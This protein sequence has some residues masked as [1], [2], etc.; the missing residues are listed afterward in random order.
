VQTIAPNVSG[1]LPSLIVFP[2]SMYAAC[3]YG[4]RSA[5]ALGLVVCLVGAGV[6]TAELAI[7]A[8]PGQGRAPVVAIYGTSLAVAIVGWSLGLFRRV[9]LAYIAA[10]EERAARAEADREERA[11]AAV[12]E[13]RTRIA[14]EMHDVVAHSLA[15]IVS[16]AQGGRYVARS[17]PE[18]AGAVLATIAETGRQALADMRG[19]L[20]VLRPDAPATGDERSSWTPQPTLAELPEL[21]ERVRDAG[22]PV[23]FRESGAARPLGPAAELAIYRLVQEALTNVLKHAGSGA[24]ATVR[25]DWG[26][27]G[28]T[29]DVRDTGN[30]GVPS[31]G[32]GHGL[33]GMRE[34]LASVGGSVTAGPLPEGGFKVEARLPWREYDVRGVGG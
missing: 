10:L 12:R 19:L 8:Q 6:I 5:P 13:E 21:L 15:V 17:D 25:L 3:A 4:R 26:E 32:D 16:Q 2:F 11:R 18:R 24:E 27:Q 33:I 7:N 1:L 30:G 28:L 9:Q 22:L 29:V 20:D 23:M 31:A 14:H 34:R